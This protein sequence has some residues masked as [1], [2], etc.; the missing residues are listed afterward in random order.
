MIPLRSLVNWCFT[1]I[2]RFIA[3][4]WYYIE[5]NCFLCFIFTLIWEGLN[6]NI[7]NFCHKICCMV[8]SVNTWFIVLLTCE[9]R[10]RFIL[11]LNEDH[12]LKI[13]WVR[14]SVYSEFYCLLPWLTSSVGDLRRIQWIADAICH[15]LFI[16]LRLSSYLP[17]DGAA[18]ADLFASRSKCW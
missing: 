11:K 17:Q 9:I 12:L 16:L 4:F 14:W 13:I 7:L 18:R 15:V 5:I 6:D 3:L 10:F 1:I 8:I 2:L